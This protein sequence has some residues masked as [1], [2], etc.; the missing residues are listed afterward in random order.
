MQA[1]Y[2]DQHRDLHGGTGYE[3]ETAADHLHLFIPFSPW[4][5]RPRSLRA[6]AG[7]ARTARPIGAAPRPRRRRGQGRAR[8]RAVVQSARRSTPATCGPASTA[9]RRSSSAPARRI[10]PRH[11]KIGLLRPRPWQRRRAERAR[12]IHGRRGRRRLR[13]RPN[14]RSAHSTSWAARGWV[15]R[16]ATS[17]SIR[18]PRR[19]DVSRPLRDGRLA[20]SRPL[21]RRTRSLDPGVSRT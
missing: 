12:S 4:R 5:G 18:P 8:R 6:Y 3:Y 17:A 13:G 21:R 19:W 10:S 7:D 1:L 2:S 11:A 16:R 15:A 14:R 9:R 20:A